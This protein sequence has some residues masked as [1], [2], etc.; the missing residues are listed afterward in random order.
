MNTPALD[1]LVALG[2]FERAQ[3][4]VTIDGVDPL[5]GT[6][7]RVG[8]AGAAAFAA[9]G[10]A[11]A[12]L[13]AGRSGRSQS[14]RVDTRAAIASLRSVDYLRVNGEIPPEHRARLSAFYP[15]RDGWVRL[16]MNFRPHREA[17]LRVLGAAPD[18]D[19][20][21]AA[22]AGWDGVALED[23]IHEAGGCSGFVRSAAVWAGHPQ[24]AAIASTPVIEFA[25]LG[26]TEPQPL[27]AG[28]RPLSGVRVLDL[29]RVLAGP[30][31]ARALAEHGADVL[32]ITAEHLD[33]S[34]GSD[35]DTGLGKRSAR[36]D[37]RRADD[38]ERLRALVR[39]ADV[40]VQSYR[41]GA[42]ARYGLGPEDL[43][44]LRPGL[45]YVSLTAWSREGPW[46]HR[47]GFDTIVQSVSGIAHET[48]DGSV[49]KMLDF[50]PID[51]ISG[52]L[53]AYG[54][55][56]ALAK[57]TRAGGSWHVLVSLARTG[58]WIVDRGLLPKA[59]VEG[60]A[61][62]LP[63]ADTAPLLIESAS[64]MGRLQHLRP[65]PEMSLTP[66][67]WERPAVP[68]GHDAPAWD[69]APSIRS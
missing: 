65:V 58:Q 64:P 46:R 67:R 24:A 44:A 37:L 30:M 62:T 22:T 13:Y 23:A 7:F 26:A 17:A 57:R 31:S 25:S 50:Q 39:E 8:D 16:H 10:L 11:A 33:D 60:L 42:L 12:E 54:A 19:A 27:G 2:G 20:I 14:V 5:I 47:R 3:T 32:K 1:E 69:A 40:F 15:T 43:A 4:P 18:R 28:A 41:P 56:A 35:I 63:A 6:R 36:L 9:T 51:Y 45:V 34:P 52:A 61:T 66:P 21:G 49:P 29:T 55:M 68:L 38:V 53:L 59:S 48:G